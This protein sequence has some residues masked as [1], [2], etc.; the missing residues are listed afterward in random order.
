MFVKVFDYV[1][2]A[3]IYVEMN[4]TLFKI[5]SYRTPYRYLRVHFLYRTPCGIADTFAVYRWRYKQQF[6]ITLVVFGFDDNTADGFS[7]LNDPVC[8]AVIN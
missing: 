4:V 2:S 8:R 7:V 3:A 1:E 6:K 5:R